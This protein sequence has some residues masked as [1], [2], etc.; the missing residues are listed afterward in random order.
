MTL[1]ELAGRLHRWTHQLREYDF[2]VVYRPGSSN[3][4]AD[5]L[6][7]APVRVVTAASQET[8]IRPNGGRA[9]EG[10]AGQL[11]DQAIQAEQAQDRTVQNLVRNGKYGGRKIIVEDEVVH[12]M[13]ND[14]SKRVV[15]P[16][17]LW[18]AALRENH[19]SIYACH[20][21]TPQTYARVA[22]SY[23]WPDMRAHVRKWV[24]ACRDCGTR[25]A[26]A[27]EV[28]PPLRS[29]GVG[30]PG[31]RWA[32]DVAGPSPVTAG[33][34][35][36]V[37]AAV[38]YATRYTMAVAV[39]RH[40]SQYI[41]R[42]F[43]EKLVLVF[44]PMRELV[45]DGAPEL[46]GKVVAALTDLL[47]TKQ[48]SP[49]PYRPA[50]LGLVERF[51][52]SWKDM[53]SIYVAG[54]QNDWDRWLPCAVYAYNGARHSAT[55]FSPNELMMGRRLRTPNELLRTA[56]VTQVGE[57][58]EYHRKLVRQMALAK[59]QLQRE[60]YY[61]RRERHT[62][63][64]GVG[65][66]VWV[67][68]PP[69][70]KGITKLSH[71]WVGPALITEDAGFDNWRVLRED[72]GE[73]LVVH[74]SFLVTSRCPNDSLG[75]V[76][77][78]ILRELGEDENESDGTYQAEMPPA[79]NE[80]ELQIRQR[81]AAGG[82]TANGPVGARSTPVAAPDRP[83]ATRIAGQG[84]ATE[85][86]RLVARSE[87]TVGAAAAPQSS[88]R[89][90]RETAVA[91]ETKDG[92]TQPPAQRQR[93]EEASAA[94]KARASRRQAARDEQEA[95]EAPA[96]GADGDRGLRDGREANG[97]D[98]RAV[99]A[100]AREVRAGQQHG[101][102]GGGSVTTLAQLGDDTEA[103]EMLRGRGQPRQPVPMPE[104]LQVPTAGYIVVRARRRVRNRAGTH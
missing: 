69:H 29:Q 59:D 26:K 21:R 12:I 50:L 99:R 32:L 9:G 81:S 63:E 28:I 7:R 17:A 18:A 72:T 74:C 78:W 103:V 73:H 13:E 24:Q 96:V 100:P 56:G 66:L 71:Q 1:K 43:V 102:T 11:I 6:F 54:A 15:L 60:K 35:R 36:Y 8:E 97:A 27:K 47:Q 5:A 55:G 53:V 94:R 93:Q 61:N 64:F 83:R 90:K 22:R 87:G 25:K 44:G 65:D 67:L 14:G 88:K 68:R 104:L 62:T 45:L 48:I 85:A 20:L 40:T 46:S 77:E 16:T 91:E 92:G 10:S 86:A 76:A 33:E 52:R 23:W 70:G 80:A 95:P 37:V 57:F 82:E 3:V 30:S 98:G 58:A 19:D 41:A 49:V 75:H 51:H 101:G 38:D 79:S 34:N 42:F 39:P 84:D 89:R 2:E 4:I 31:D